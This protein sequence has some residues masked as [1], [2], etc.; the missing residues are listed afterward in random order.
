MHAVEQGQAD[1]PEGA[2]QAEGYL[3]IRSR[4]Q[5]DHRTGELAM[6]DLGLDSKLRDCDLVKLRLRDVCHGS[7]IAGRATVMKQKTQ[8]PE[9]FEITPS[10]PRQRKP[11]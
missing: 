4:L 9:Q 8:R 3:G 10:T 5:M 1:R 11:K 2:A 7:H 6:F